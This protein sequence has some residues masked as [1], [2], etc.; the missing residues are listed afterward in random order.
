MCDKH[1]FTLS[2]RRGPEDCNHFPVFCVSQNRQLMS[3][4]PACAVEVPSS[5]SIVTNLYPM[6]EEK[7][8]FQSMPTLTPMVC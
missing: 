1:Y 2:G 3:K 7:N 6:C 5:P 8:L 4:N